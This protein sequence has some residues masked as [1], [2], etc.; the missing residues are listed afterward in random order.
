M[1]AFL[2]PGFLCISC[3]SSHAQV[4]H[5]Q[6]VV[7][8]EGANYT[9]GSKTLTPGNYLLSD[10]NDMASSIKVSGGLVAVIC[11]HGSATMGYGIT[12]DLM[13]NHPDLSVFNFND[14]VSY[15]SVFYAEKENKYVWVR[16]SMQNGQFMPGLWQRKGVNPP[17]NMGPVVSPSRPG[18]VPTSPSVLATNGP[19]TTITSLGIQSSEGKN[20]WEIARNSQM[21]I[22]GNEY[23]GLEEIGTAAIERASNNRAI[24]NFINF[25]YPQKRQRDHRSV[26]YFKR[27]LAGTV[28]G[29]RQVF[30]EGTFEDF[31]ANIDIYPDPGYMYLLT[32]AHPPKLT[33]IMKLPYY[34]SLGYAG[35]GSCPEK[36]VTL[37][38]EM[39]E[40][41]RP[42]KGYIAR[43]KEMADTRIGKKICVYGVW[44]WDEGHC[45]HPEIHPAEQLWWSEPQANGTKYNLNVICDASRRFWW[46]DQMDDGTKLKPW[47]A[48]PIKG[49]FAIAFEYTIPGQAVMDGPAIRF[50]VSNLKQHN[51]IEYPNADQTYNLI[52]QDKN[53]VSFIPHNNAFKVS[54]EHVGVVP[55]SPNKI[56]G[57]LIIETSVG[58]LTNLTNTYSTP[59]QA[60]QDQ[61]SKHFKKED[62]HYYFTVLETSPNAGRRPLDKGNN[63]RKERTRQ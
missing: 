58:R 7:L 19:N 48:P 26:V 40:D 63:D 39:A 57:F 54:F 46:R 29:T 4:F 33:N 42:G 8:Y 13:E 59:E 25:W 36:F 44:I 22:I 55:G 24:P 61:E 17:P 21:N 1:K 18:P 12:V 11:E 37:E 41:F 16:N 35:E 31:D 30:Y 10:F 15:I 27:T 52:Y 53:I 32:D 14:K 62:G 34:G 43:I 6:N 28:K 60:P 45:C 56:R 47:A 9:G 23:R 50:E 49:L 5:Q 38:A 51:V 2:L 3:L 20:L